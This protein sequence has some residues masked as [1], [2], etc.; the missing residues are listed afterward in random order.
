[1]WL[2]KK[3]VTFEWHKKNTGTAESK[4]EVTKTKI[5]K[6]SLHTKPES[7]PN[8]T[9]LINMTITNALLNK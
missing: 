2:K 5:E 7:L 1:M 4:K 9:T 8:Y 3:V 6:I